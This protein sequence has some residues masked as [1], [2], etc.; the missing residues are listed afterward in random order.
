MDFDNMIFPTGSIFIFGSWICEADS[1]GNL[2]GRLIEA[3]KASE[4]ITLL[5][6]SAKDLTERF[7]GLTVSELT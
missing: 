5:M 3:R 6:G 2:Q 4:E 1:E 7:S